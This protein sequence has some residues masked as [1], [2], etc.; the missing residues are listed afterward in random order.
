[1]SEIFD[2][3][4]NK[5]KI[6]QLI[7]NDFISCSLDKQTVNVW[8]K[9]KNSINNPKVNKDGAFDGL[10]KT[11]ENKIGEFEGKIN[12]NDIKI[13]KEEQEKLNKEKSQDELRTYLNIMPSKEEDINKMADGLF[14]ANEARFNVLFDKDFRDELT[15]AQ[16][17]NLTK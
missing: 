11:L 6:T 14:E 12:E 1:M 2:K 4:E 16:Q 9:F 7:N 3:K 10:I 13:T 15:P 8:Y 5:D 17:D